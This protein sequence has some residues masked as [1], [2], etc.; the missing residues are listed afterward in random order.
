MKKESFFKTKKVTFFF[1][2]FA[3]VAGLFFIQYNLTGNAIL[4]KENSFSLLSIIG[5]SLLICS[6][7]LALYSVKKR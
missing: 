1:S 6:A 4:N 5:I 7:I 3:L 2:I